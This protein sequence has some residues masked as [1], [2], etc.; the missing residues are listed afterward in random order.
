MKVVK[1]SLDLLLL[2][3]FGPFAL[4]L[5]LMGAALIKLLSPGPVFYSQRRVGLGGKLIDVWK[6]RTMRVD[7]E[8]ALAK[9]LESEPAAADEWRRHFKLKDD[10]RV[11]PYIG[12]FLRKSSM[13]EL[14]QFFNILLGE[15]S[16]VGP[17]PFPEYHLRVFD[18]PFRRRRQSVL[19][20]LTGLWQIRVR[21]GGDIR[22][23]RYWDLKY[24]VGRCLMLDL[25]ILCETP[26]VVIR[27][28]GAV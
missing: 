13:D 2:L 7:A 17:R 21:S 6:L 16:F 5:I 15:M 8:Q 11:I 24:L 19:P 14:P 20:G 28:K 22:A 1:R 23:Q 4:L 26:L 10:P 18:K 3:L 25:R 9:H 12:N 27:A